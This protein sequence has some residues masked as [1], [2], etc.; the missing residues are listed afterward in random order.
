MQRRLAADLCVVGSVCAESRLRTGHLI[1]YR[2]S[3]QQA[4]NVLH[5]GA[6]PRAE[7]HGDMRLRSHKS[8]TDSCR[9][10]GADKTLGPQTCARADRG[11]GFAQALVSCTRTRLRY[12]GTSCSWRL[13][14]GRLLIHRCTITIARACACDAVQA[15]W[16]DQLL[17]VLAICTIIALS[18]SLPLCCRG[19]VGCGGKR[20]W[21]SRCSTAAA[22]P[23]SVGILLHA[24]PPPAEMRPAVGDEQRHVVRI[25]F[26]RLD[27]VDGLSRVSCLAFV[28]CRCH[29]PLSCVMAATP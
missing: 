10:I 22:P 21:A 25:R 14:G 4:P 28:A 16:C 17:H 23:C 15:M 6:G 1:R 13:A 19:P 8:E 12:A 2:L 29:R 18:P 3:A 7:A 20:R 9:V 24:P 26:L 27:A 5:V 11:K